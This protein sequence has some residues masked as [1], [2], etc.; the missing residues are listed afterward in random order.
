MIMLVVVKVV[1]RRRCDHI[2][3]H[4]SREKV[5]LA[6]EKV[7]ESKVDAPAAPARSVHS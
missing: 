6:G 5:E 4:E 7:E 1:A 2:R 3:R